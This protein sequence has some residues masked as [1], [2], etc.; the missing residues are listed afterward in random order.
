MVIVLGTSKLFPNNV[1][2][3]NEAENS[4]SAAAVNEIV[5]DRHVSLN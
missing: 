1:F 5:L 4:L 2:P 3:K